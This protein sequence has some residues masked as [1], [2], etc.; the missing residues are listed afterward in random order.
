[1]TQ[2][3]YQLYEQHPEACAK[4]LGAGYKSRTVR[5]PGVYARFGEVLHDSACVIKRVGDVEEGKEHLLAYTI[6]AVI[7]KHPDI[8]TS[9]NF[10]VEFQFAQKNHSMFEHS[11]RI[12]HLDIEYAEQLIARVYEAV[13]Q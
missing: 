6:F 10:F 3:F 1:M 13:K 12:E 5:D 2:G 4:L 11:Q 7:V 9:V 8:V